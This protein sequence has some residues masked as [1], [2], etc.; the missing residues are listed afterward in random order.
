MG[1]RAKRRRSHVALSL[2]LFRRW[3]M[4]GPD[5]WKPK[6]KVP[7]LSEKA[8]S[9]LV[10]VRRWTWRIH[11]AVPSYSWKRARP[12]SLRQLTTKSVMTTNVLTR[13][14]CMTTMQW[15]HTWPC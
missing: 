15:Q 8:N 10:A 2:A 3:R 11:P 4:D 13:E 7:P 6:I 5:D 9:R 12:T 14:P 1:Q